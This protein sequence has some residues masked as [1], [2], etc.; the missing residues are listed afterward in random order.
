M[1]GL[2]SVTLNRLG[3]TAGDSDEGVNLVRFCAV[4]L[5]FPAFVFLYLVQ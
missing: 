5:N 4:S 2:C 1:G 3:Q